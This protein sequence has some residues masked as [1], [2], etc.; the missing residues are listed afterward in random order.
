MNSKGGVQWCAQ[1]RDYMMPLEMMDLA[2]LRENDKHKPCEAGCSLGCVRMVSH[3]LG[4]PLKT[5]GASVKLALGMKAA[6]SKPKA[7]VAVAV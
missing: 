6:T 4:E 1:Q 5:F 2:K 3:T 7:Q